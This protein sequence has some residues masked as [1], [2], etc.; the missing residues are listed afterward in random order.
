MAIVW[1]ERLMSTGVAE[2]DAQHRKLIDQLNGLFTAL[3]SGVPDAEVKKMLTF[4]GE[5]TAWHFG[6]EEKCFAKFAC[7]AAEANKAAH[8]SFLGIFKGIADKVESEGVTSAL[9][10]QTQQAV[11]DWVRN[12]IVRIDTKSRPCAATA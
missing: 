7:P 12:H 1:N 10:L 6:D 2:I 9:A 8:A 11:S 3:D 5:Y 4:L